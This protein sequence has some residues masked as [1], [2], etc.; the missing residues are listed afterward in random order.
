MPRRAASQPSLRVVSTGS[1]NGGRSGASLRVRTG[2]SAPSSTTGP[3]RWLR[4]EG[5][6]APEPRNHARSGWDATTLIEPVEMPRRVGSQPSLLGVLAG[7][8]ERGVVPPPVRRAR[9][10]G[11]R[12]TSRQLAEDDGPVAVQQHPGL[13]V[14]AHRPGEHR[15]LD[16]AAG[17]DEL[18]GGVGV[19]DAGDVLLD[20]RA[21]VEVAGDV[22][23]GGA[24]QLD[25][26]LEG[27]VVGA[28]ALERGQERVVDVDGAA[29]QPAAQ[30]GR[31][32][33]ACSGPAR[34][35]GRRGRRPAPAAS[36]SAS[37]LVSGVTGMWWNSMP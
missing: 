15:R 7:R 21:L 29:A 17:G 37:G 9:S 14:P 13:R 22:V 18:L 23:G 2:A 5:A 26:A 31:T 30:C 25:A 27:R 36:A 24:D 12:R 3:P 4:C 1:T 11:P 19:V 20:D 10:R 16:V 35:G 6:L 28:R 33:S 8:A 32:G 34:P